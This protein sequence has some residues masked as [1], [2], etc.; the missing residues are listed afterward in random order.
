VFLRKPGTVKV[1]FRRRRRRLR[2][3][4]RSAANN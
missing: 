1:V 3:M 2:P 4:V